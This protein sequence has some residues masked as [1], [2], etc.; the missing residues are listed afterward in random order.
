MWINRILGYILVY[1]VFN[2]NEDTI[3]SK[4]VD[5]S[6]VKASIRNNPLIFDKIVL[7]ENYGNAKFYISKDNLE[8]YNNTNFKISISKNKDFRET[9]IGEFYKE[10]LSENINISYVNSKSMITYG[11]EFLLGIGAIY[12]LIYLIQKISNNEDLIDYPMVGNQSNNFKI[13]KDISINFTDVIGLKSVKDDLREYVGFIENREK[14]IKDG[15]KIPRGLLLAGPPGTGKTLLAKALAGESNATFIPVSGSDF[16]EVFVGVGSQRVRELFKLARQNSPAIIFIDEIDTIG[17]KRSSSSAG[18]HSE[19]SSTLNKLLTE[20]DG[21]TDNQ[22]VLVI[23]ATNRIDSLDSAL[24]RSGRFDRKI[25]FDKPNKNERREMFRLYLG[26]V[27][28]SEEFKASEDLNITKLGDM[29][30]GLSGAD[31]ANS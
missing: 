26:K 5:D 12:I 22:N 3:Y 30:A 15:C 20:M 13:T 9:L 4:V 31:I 28:I 6:I 10:N 2:F 19:H 16:I 18:G 27:N 17:T 23:A 21:F 7:D 1:F 11:L 25:I 24:T 14:Y 29:T 8:D